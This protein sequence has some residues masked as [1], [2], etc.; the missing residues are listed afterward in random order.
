MKIIVKKEE[1]RFQSRYLALYRSGE[2]E[3][4]NCPN[5]VSLIKSFSFY[6]ILLCYLVSYMYCIDIN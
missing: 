5:F 1:N 2:T 6:V 4:L 3:L